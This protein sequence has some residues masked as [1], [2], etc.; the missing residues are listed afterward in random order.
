MRQARNYLYKS[1]KIFPKW[2]ILTFLLHNQLVHIVGSE[3]LRINFSGSGKILC[4]LN[5]KGIDEQ[6]IEICESRIPFYLSETYF[7]F[8]SNFIWVYVQDPAS[9]IELRQNLRNKPI[10]TVICYHIF[11]VNIEYVFRAACLMRYLI[12][13]SLLQY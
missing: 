7:H 9:S 1:T 13:S 2:Y 11:L 6:T 5:P 3:P 4:S 8:G 12:S 10:A